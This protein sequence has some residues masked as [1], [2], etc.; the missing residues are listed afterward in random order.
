MVSV[1][2]W[3][4]TVQCSCCDVSFTKWL[5]RLSPA[6]YINFS[7]H[8]T[9]AAQSLADLYSY[10]DL[11]D[12]LFHDSLASCHLAFSSIP[13]QKPNQITNSSVKLYG[14]EHIK[15]T[16]HSVAFYMLS[17]NS[18]DDKTPINIHTQNTKCTHKWSQ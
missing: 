14:N 3:L 15:Y 1:V 7:R 8:S 5:C 16:E 6:S 11:F 17:Q 12:S 9:S 4:L 2:H 13:I 10:S 18:I